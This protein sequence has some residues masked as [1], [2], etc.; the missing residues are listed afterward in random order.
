MSASPRAARG[1][2][3]SFDIRHVPHSLDERFDRQ[4]G[5]QENSGHD[6]R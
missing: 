6:R 5:E 4:S 2:V 3:V 1:V